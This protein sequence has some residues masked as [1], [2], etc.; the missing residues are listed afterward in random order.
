[1]YVDPGS[2]NQDAYIG[3]WQFNRDANKS[4]SGLPNMFIIFLKLLPGMAHS[5]ES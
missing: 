5:A 1:M 3:N 2:G 4:M